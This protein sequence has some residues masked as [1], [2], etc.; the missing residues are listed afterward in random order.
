MSAARLNSRALTVRGTLPQIGSFSLE[1]FVKRSDLCQDI[2]LTCCMA[3]SMI[4]P[5]HFDCGRQ[6]ALC[7]YGKPFLRA[8]EFAWSTPRWA[9]FIEAPCL[10]RRCGGKAILLVDQIADF[11]RSLF[12]VGPRDAFSDDVETLVRRWLYTL[13]RMEVPRCR[14]LL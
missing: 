6:A 2:D 13:R 11:H 12:A 3:A 10:T 14:E 5:P 1:S 9:P 8:A 7:L 4:E